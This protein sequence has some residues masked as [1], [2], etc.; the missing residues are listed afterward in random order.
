MNMVALLGWVGFQKVNENVSG[1]MAYRLNR[2]EISVI[3]S[4]SFSFGL[5]SSAWSSAHISSIK[6]VHGS[7]DRNVLSENNMA[8]AISK[9]L[10]SRKNSLPV[11]CRHPS[12]V[13]NWSNLEVP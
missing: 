11:P 2:S 1:G 8:R 7:V 12:G 4:S 6:L 9:T 10:T 13:R 3:I 5:H